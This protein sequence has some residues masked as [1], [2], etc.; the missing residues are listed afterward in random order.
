M[1]AIYKKALTIKS[2][3]NTY[4]LEQ[5]RLND[6]LLKMSLIIKDNENIL[7]IFNNEFSLNEL[8]NGNNFFNDCNSIKEII[9]F[10]LTIIKKKKMEIVEVERNNNDFYYLIFYNE[11]KNNNYKF[12]LNNVNQNNEINIIS[13]NPEKISVKKSVIESQNLPSN[14][15][16]SI[17][18]SSLNIDSNMNVYKENNNNI[19]FTDKPKE[20]NEKKNYI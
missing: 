17:F 2:H 14:Y 3:N 1:N 13:E 8:K 11:L 9:D 12:K 19:F 16:H 20:F 7:N 6:N 5:I 18:K 10:L 4:E 15:N